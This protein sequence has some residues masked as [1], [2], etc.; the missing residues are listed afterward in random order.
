[1]YAIDIK[2]TMA[3]FF[4]GFD[5]FFCASITLTSGTRSWPVGYFIINSFFITL[6]HPLHILSPHRQ[7]SASCLCFFTLLQKSLLG[8]NNFFPCREVINCILY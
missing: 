8:R 5:N 4:Y 2:A 1:M 7:Y 3:W 6:K